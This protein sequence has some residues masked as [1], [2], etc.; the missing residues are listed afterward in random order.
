MATVAELRTSAVQHTSAVS[1]SFVSG[2]RDFSQS[3]VQM[4][5]MHGVGNLSATVAISNCVQEAYKRDMGSWW[6]QKGSGSPS[7]RRLRFVA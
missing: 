5:D 4:E 2:W 6:C 3:G 1:G 7:P